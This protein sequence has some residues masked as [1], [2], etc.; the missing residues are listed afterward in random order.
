MTDADLLKLTRQEIPISSTAY[1]EQIAFQVESAK[2]MIQREGITLDVSKNEDCTLIIGYAAFLFR[3]KR[4]D[5]KE[6]PRWLRYALNNR[7]FS[8]KAGA[9]DV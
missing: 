5:V 2:E 9:G 7:L 1:D 8:E 6:M 4:G 3:Q